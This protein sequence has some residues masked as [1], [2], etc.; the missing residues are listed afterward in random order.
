MKIYNSLTREKEEFKPIK[1][2]CAGMYVCGPTV[3]DEPHIGHARA[4]YIFEVIKNYLQYKGLKVKFIKNI[5]DIDDKII[6][7]AKEELAGVEIEQ[8]VINIAH[9]Y[10]R[11]YYEDMDI[12]G[13]SRADEAPLA[14]EH[15]PQMIEFIDRLVNKGYA[16]PVDGDVYFDVRKFKNY[17]RLSHQNTEEM[18]NAV[19]IAKD[20]KKQD[21]LDFA[22][23]K[24][25][26]V[27]EPAWE[28]PWGRGRPGWHIECSVMS[29][30]YL[31]D[32]FDIHGGGIDLIFPHHENEIAQSQADGKAFAR[33]WMHNGLLTINGQKMAKSLGNFITIKDFLE[34]YKHPNI[35]KL[36]FLATHY[37]NPIDYTEQKIEEAKH[38]NERMLTMVKNVND[39][40]NRIDAV[41]RESIER[42]ASVETQNFAS[43]RNAFNEA[44]DNDFNTPV[45]TAILYQ[46]ITEANVMVMKSVETQ[47]FAF[48]H[49]Y[50]KLFGKITSVFGID[51]GTASAV[52]AD[53]DSEIT[54]L[55]K[56]R[57]QAREQKDFKLA[58]EIRQRLI[59][60]GIV[61]EDTK[62]GTVWRGNKV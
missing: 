46:M 47:N 27:D 28:S 34:K 9:K 38:L 57:N 44:M 14:T 32:E 55:I 8:A 26:Q 2:G 49:D 37:R 33:I 20:E 21:A 7:K 41:R 16:Y 3:Y 62:A 31:G 11:R 4:A 25:S 5:T 39:L 40:L 30:Q 45:V 24:K 29:S 17:G 61:L 19:R 12:L 48:L 53:L 35:L 22:L 54:R 18:C 1:P 60:D 51:L 13:I 56:K 15:I 6:A 42:S 23:W 52:D 58:D 50:Y 59:K 43:L 36:F 10:T